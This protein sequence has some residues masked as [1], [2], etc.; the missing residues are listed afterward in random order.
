MILKGDI[1]VGDGRW[2]KSREINV[3][4]RVERIAEVISHGVLYH[5]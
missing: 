2:R 1:V 4:V 3:R 5:R